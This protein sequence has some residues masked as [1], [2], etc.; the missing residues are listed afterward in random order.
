[1]T[2]DLKTVNE[3]AS[4]FSLWTSGSAFSGIF[5]EAKA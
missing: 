1:M 4:G 2:A 5:L 3:S